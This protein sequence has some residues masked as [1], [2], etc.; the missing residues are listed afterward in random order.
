MEVALPIILFVAGFGVGAFVVWQIKQREIEDRQQ[1]QA[2]LESAFGNL[3]RQALMENQT[4]FMELARGE[5]QKLEQQ[6]GQ[7]LN[8]KK[9]LIDS[10]LKTISSSVQQLSEGT[11]RL[12][13]SVESTTRRLDNL[14]ETTD[15][16]R[17]ILSSSQARGQWGERM[18]EDILN[19]LGLFLVLFLIFFLEKFEVDLGLLDLGFLFNDSS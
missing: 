19:L 4:Q 2:D 11:A 17:Q 3:S 7:Q 12:H 9:E 15:Q 5:F 13:G 18:V 14:T 8:Q 10:S 1:A 16:L 6:S